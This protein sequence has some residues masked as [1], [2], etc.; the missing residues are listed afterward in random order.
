MNVYCRDCKIILFT[1]DESTDEKQIKFLHT[2]VAPHAPKGIMVKEIYSCRD[3]SD[4]RIGLSDDPPGT[5]RKRT[6]TK[7]ADR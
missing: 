3:C 6:G 4:K 1:L 2:D 5:K 7:L